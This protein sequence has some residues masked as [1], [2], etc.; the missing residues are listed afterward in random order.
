[1][2]QGLARLA[3]LEQAELLERS[4]RLEISTANMYSTEYGWA[5]RL[6]LNAK[7]KLRRA[8]GIRRGVN[9]NRAVDERGYGIL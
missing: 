6:H 1:M 7:D 9:D 3:E 8:E 5:N 4:A 2:K